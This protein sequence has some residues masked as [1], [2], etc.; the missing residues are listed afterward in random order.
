[1]T[2]DGVATKGIALKGC[3]KSDKRFRLAF[4]VRSNDVECLP[5]KLFKIARRSKCY[6]C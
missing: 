4:T 1:M 5:T 6:P 3:T 2:L